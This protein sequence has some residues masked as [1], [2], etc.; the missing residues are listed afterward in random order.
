VAFVP[1]GGAEAAGC[2]NTG[3]EI[4]NAPTATMPIKRCFMVQPSLI[5]N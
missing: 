5:W 3:A 4:A 2:A 1:G